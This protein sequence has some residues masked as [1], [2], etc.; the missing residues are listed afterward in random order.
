M[1][2]SQSCAVLLPCR[3]ATVRGRGDRVRGVQEGTAVQVRHE[4]WLVW[5]LL[6]RYKIVG[7]LSPFRSPLFRDTFLFIG[8]QT[9]RDFSDQDSARPRDQAFCGILFGW[10]F[11]GVWDLGD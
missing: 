3:G 10:C 1:P 7:A 6:R 11:S 9:E 2:P 4:V 8:A 5:C